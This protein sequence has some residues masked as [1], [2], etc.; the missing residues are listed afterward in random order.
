[1]SVR[2]WLDRF[3]A[4]YYVHRPVNATF[5]GVHEHDHRLPDFSEHGAGDALAD[6]EGLLRESASLPAEADRRSDTPRPGE[7]AAPRSAAGPS[8][9][10]D[11]RFKSVDRRLAEGF[12]RIQL[13]EYR[14]D[15]FH[16]GNPSVYTG[17]AVFGLLSLFLTDFAPVSE[18]A[19]AATARME[20]VAALLEQGRENVGQAPA[21][22]TGRALRECEGALAFLTEGIDIL[23]AENQITTP[24]FKMAAERAAKAFGDFESHLDKELLARTTDKHACG[25]EAFRLYLTD[26]HCVDTD[27]DEI[28]AYAEAEGVDAAAAFESGARDLAAA[29]GRTTHGAGATTRR[30]GQRAGAGDGHEL[31]A[32]LA[33]LHPTVEGYYDRYQEVWDVVRETAEAQQLLTWPDFPI[34]YVPRP[35]WVRKAAP[36]L[37]FLFYRSPAAFGRPD[38]HDYLVT[39][40]E[41]GM[42]PDRQLELLEATNNSV[43]KLNHVIHHGSI[44]HHVQNWHAFRSASRIGQMAAVDCASRIAMFCGGTM[45]EGWA[46]YATDLMREAGALT[47]LEELAEHRGRMRMCA[48]AVVDVRL[49]LG[50][51]TLED[52]IVHYEREAGMTPFAA[53]SEAVKNSMFPGAAVMYLLGRD[54]VHRLRRETEKHQGARF[55]LRSFHD[56]LLSYGS[57]PVSVIGAAMKGKDDHAA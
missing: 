12:L 22:W 15:H 21:A 55:S 26:G 43:I 50:R 3:F 53:R 40:I 1:M 52:A 29:D 56:E 18:R 8:D 34:R 32:G 25:E 6:L 38:V 36:Y 33:C 54:G 17:E 49:H 19:E 45:A 4:S 41:A 13:W 11:Q 35:T 48:R 46:C 5:I 51:I 24:G 47:P 57:I 37:Y 16:R 2:G 27:P 23:A 10:A 7:E 44:G 42:P 14:S 9:S 20:A 39:P 30:D 31:L 28:L